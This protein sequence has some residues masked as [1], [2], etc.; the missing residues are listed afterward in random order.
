MI[1]IRLRLVVAGSFLFVGFLH[2]QTPAVCRPGPP[3]ARLRQIS[4]HDARL[5]LQ[6]AR[7]DSTV[8]PGLIQHAFLIKP[9]LIELVTDQD[10]TI[11]ADAI[12]M[13]GAIALNGS[14]ALVKEAALS[15][16]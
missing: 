12:D 11:R 14:T 3:Y 5:C 1:E 10:S 8:R 15:L 9:S 2:G 4:S 7:I 16:L 13:L 6:A